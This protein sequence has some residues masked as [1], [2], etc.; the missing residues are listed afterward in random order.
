[1]IEEHG[2]F[3]HDVFAGSPQVRPLVT[4][5]DGEIYGLPQVNE[6][7]HCFYSQR[8]WINSD[9]LANVGMGVPQTTEEFVDV[10]TAFKEQDANGNGDPR[11]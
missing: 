11:R 3:I 9:W 1:M 2:H 6:C 8:A 10:L 5:P 7:Y 4:S